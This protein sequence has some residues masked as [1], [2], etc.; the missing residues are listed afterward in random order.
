[1]MQAAVFDKHGGS[2]VIQVKQVARPTPSTD[3]VLIRVEAIGVN[4]V[5]T[6]IRNGMFG[7]MPVPHILGMD[8]AGVVEECGEDVTSFKKGDRV[9][10]YHKQFTGAGTYAEYVAVPQSDAHHLHDKMTFEEGAALGIPYLTAEHALVHSTR[11]KPGEYCFVHGASGGVGVA[12]VQVARG[13]GLHVV[14]TAGTDE[15]CKD[16]ER[17]GAEFAINHCTEGYMDEIRS[18]LDGNGVD[19]VLEMLG[20][21]NLAKDMEALN[22]GG[23]ITVIGT[24][25]PEVTINPMLFLQKEMQINGTRVFNAS[26]EQ[27]TQYCAHLA[28][29]ADLGWLKPI[30]G[31]R[32]K[33]SQ[34]K[35]AHEE[36]MNGRAKGKMVLI[37]DQ[38]WK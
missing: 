17:N 2:E 20:D 37:P 10:I 31:K 18:R 11:A 24:R 12:S 26:A 33:L 6:Y 35:E 9:W 32:Y 19:V 5:E 36:I 22:C 3:E 15:S 8:A 27:V 14:G 7:E 16:V 38:L 4:P 25:G 13:I 1:M 30:V 34:V 29:G 21:K 28:S 23:R